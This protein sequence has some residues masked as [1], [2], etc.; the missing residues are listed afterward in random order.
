M[1]IERLKGGRYRI[2]YYEKARSRAGGPGEPRP[3]L[4]QGS[5]EASH[6]RA[7]EGRGSPGQGNGPYDVHRALPPLHG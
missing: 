1:S 5:Q 6:R 3:R 7:R 4:F 2:R